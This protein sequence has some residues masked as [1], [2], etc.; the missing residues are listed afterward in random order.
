MALDTQLSNAAVNAQADALARLLDNGY[1]RIYGAA[2]PANADTALSG[3][4][5]LAEPRFNAT[6]APAASGGVLTFNAFT[7]DSAANNDGVAVWFRAYKSDGTTAVLDGTVGTSSANLVMADTTI[8]AGALV[9]V[10]SLTH[11]V[12]KATTGY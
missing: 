7:A 9:Q 10:T 6:S 5:L 12:A 2:K 3:Q 8:F 11:T 1:C 4:T